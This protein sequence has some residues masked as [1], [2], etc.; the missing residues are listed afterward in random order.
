[1]PKQFLFGASTLAIILSVP[2]LAVAADAID[3]SVS[4][5]PATIDVLTRNVGRPSIRSPVGPMS[6]R[7]PPTP[8]KV[9]SVVLSRLAIATAS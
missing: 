3:G 5:T 7:D 2:A 9:Q 4:E 8:Q 6:S 1:M